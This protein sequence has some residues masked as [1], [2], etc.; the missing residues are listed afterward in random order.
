MYEVIIVTGDADNAG[1]DKRVHFSLIYEDGGERTSQFLRPGQQ[2]IE[3][4]SYKRGQLDF[5]PNCN[6]K[7][8]NGDSVDSGSVVGVNVWFTG[9]KWLLEKVWVTHNGTGRAVC[10]HLAEPVWLGDDSGIGDSE[11][12]AYRLDLS[13]DTVPDD[14]TG[15]TFLTFTLKVTTQEATDQ[16]PHPGTNDQVYYKLF[17]ADGLASQC[18]RAQ[19]FGNQY[20]PGETNTFNGWDV[21]FAPL[22][23]RVHRVLIFKRADIG[24]DAWRPDRLEVL[25]GPIGLGAPRNR[26]QL[27]E[28]IPD[29]LS[30]HH[31]WAYVDA[32]ALP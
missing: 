7:D 27:T 11:G 31:S 13:P 9:D 25:P 28:A 23:S 30:G 21:G 10:S 16:H 3:H 2:S 15:D 5:C 8:E 22:D 32:V 12:N 6:F 24:D 20:Q 14:A 1:T 17:G 26:F 29:G 4:N 18:D 19:A